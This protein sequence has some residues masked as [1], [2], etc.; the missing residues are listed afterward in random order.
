VDDVSSY[1][2]AVFRRSRVASVTVALTL[3][4][5]PIIATGCGGGS[6]KSSGA[7]SSTSTTTSPPLSKAAYEQ[8]L[9]PVLNDEV[10]PATRKA[11]A[12]GGAADPR[13]VNEVI[14]ELKTAQRA[15]TSITP[16]VEVADLHKAAIAVIG[17][18]ISDAARLRDA[19]TAHDS[20]SIA[21]AAAALKVD[22]QR[23]QSVG[24]QFT[25]RGY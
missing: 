2:P 23:M 24:S 1:A 21:A 7:N 9:G 14:G 19:E 16:P 10:V 20:A 17:A 3:T 4:L 15:M 11:F 25:A 22:A 5:I 12:N 18:M 13:K 8:Q 6:S